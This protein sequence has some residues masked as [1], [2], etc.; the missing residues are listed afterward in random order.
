MANKFD[1]FS[2]E[3]A[4]R[5]SRRGV[6]KYLGV[7]VVGAAA[8]AIAGTRQTE[9]SPRRWFEIFN[10]CRGYRGR[11]FLT[12]L[13]ETACTS[14]G[15]SIC[16]AGEIKICCPPG[17]QCIG[18]NGTTTTGPLGFLNSYRCVPMTVNGTLPF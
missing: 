8:A 14:Y 12:C 2:R 11:D 5:H 6:L 7:G 3:L 1:D 16:G 18:I 13:K 9:A 17:T 15:G 10:S 4:A